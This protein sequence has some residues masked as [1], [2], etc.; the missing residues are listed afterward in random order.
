M[1]IRSYI[2]LLLEREKIIAVV[3]ESHHAFLSIEQNI[4]FSNHY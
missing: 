2:I 3:N 1:S 4:V